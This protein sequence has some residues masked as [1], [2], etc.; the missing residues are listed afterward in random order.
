ME[1]LEIGNFYRYGEFLITRQEEEPLILPEAF[2]SVVLS[3]DNQ[4]GWIA[5][6]EME[7]DSR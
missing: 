5:A 4:G 6:V 2:S 1:M 7:S 3:P